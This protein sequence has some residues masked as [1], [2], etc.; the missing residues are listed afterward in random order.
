MNK[1]FHTSLALSTLLALGTVA[2][3]GDDDPIDD[4]FS[5]FSSG[6]ADSI[7]GEDSPE[8]L[9]IR[10]LVNDKSVDFEE[11]DIDARLHATAARN[12][13]KH[14]DGPDEL[15]DTADDDDYDTLQ[16]LERSHRQAD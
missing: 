2:C 9:A 1:K 15:P 14:R 4:E 16:E 12:I 6:K 11:L 10:A 5:D 8:A 3:S 7:F 13:I